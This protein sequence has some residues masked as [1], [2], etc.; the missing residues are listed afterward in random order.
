MPRTK[1]GPSS[2]PSRSRPRRPRWAACDSAAPSPG[3]GR[4]SPPA[5]PPPAA[6]RARPPRPTATTSTATPC[7]RRR[8]SQAPVPRR[9]SPLAQVEPHRRG[10]LR[11]RLHRHD[12]VARQRGARRPE[13]GLLAHRARRS[14]RPATRPGRHGGA[15]G[16]GRG[17]ERDPRPPLVGPRRLQHDARPAA[18]G[19]RALARLLD[20]VAG[21]YRSDGRVFF[22]LY[23]EPR[24]RRARSGSPGACPRAT[25]SPA[26]SSSTTRCAPPAPRTS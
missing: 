12:R 24:R 3:S 14:T 22:E 9:R 20:R 23:N 25:W 7:A 13:P 10:P 18:H 6:P 21:R 17:D 26:C 15:V 4:C 11:G 8:A 19:R 1:T 5:A 2:S 16:R